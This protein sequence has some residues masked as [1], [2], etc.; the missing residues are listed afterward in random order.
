MGPYVIGVMF[1]FFL[2]DR[3]QR[4]RDTGRVP[5]YILWPLYGAIT[6]LLFWPVYGTKYLYDTDRAQGGFTKW[7]NVFYISLARSGWALGIG[8]LATLAY[9][10]YGGIVCCQL[11]ADVVFFFCIHRGLSPHLLTSV[12]TVAI[13]PLDS[14]ARDLDPDGASDLPCLSRPSDDLDSHIRWC[15][16][17]SRVL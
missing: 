14:G 6:M 8:L 10:G 12:L 4:G 13:G 3:K 1:A 9:W 2:Q 17:V 11:L 15:S 5:V 7:G 16:R